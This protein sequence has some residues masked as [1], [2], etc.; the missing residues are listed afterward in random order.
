MANTKLKKRK[1]GVVGA[2]GL[3]YDAGTIKEQIIIFLVV[4]LCHL[5]STMMIS[6]VFLIDQRDS[7]LCVNLLRRQLFP[8]QYV[9]RFIFRWTS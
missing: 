3:N 5:L 7:A 4:F 8:Q 2:N 9:E 6:T 1:K